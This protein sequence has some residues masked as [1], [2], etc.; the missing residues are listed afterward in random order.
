MTRRRL[1]LEELS[2]PSQFCF[3]LKLLTDLLLLFLVGFAFLSFLFL[4]L[5]ISEIKVSRSEERGLGMSS[6][7]SLAKRLLRCQLLI[8]AQL[9]AIPSCLFKNRPSSFMP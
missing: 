3:C 2:S 1:V 8:L 5:V 4:P 9:N 6:L 7:L